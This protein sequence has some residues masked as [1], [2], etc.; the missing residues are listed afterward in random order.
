M[1]V[2]KM[3]NSTENPLIPTLKPG[4]ENFAGAKKNELIQSLV[5][6][7]V[8]MDDHIGSL[9]DKVEVAFAINKSKQ[10]EE[11]QLNARCGMAMKFIEASLQG[12]NP[13]TI[14]EAKRRVNEVMAPL[15]DLRQDQVNGIASRKSELIGF[16]TFLL[17]ENFSKME[18]DPI[19]EA[20]EAWIE[21][22]K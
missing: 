12:A 1:A 14:E 6:Q 16:G 11:A 3:S 10:Q 22:N 17:T 9:R 15:D 4:W 18:A 5:D 13:I 8:K 2:T 19:E 20:I 7:I 21:L